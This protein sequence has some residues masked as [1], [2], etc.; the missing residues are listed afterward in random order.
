MIYIVVLVIFFI[1]V[2]IGALYNILVKMTNKVDEVFAT[3]DVYLKKRWDLI[4]SLVEMVKGYMKHE[5]DTLQEIV[6]IR[7][8]TYDSMSS[9]EKIDVNEK[10][11]KLLL[12]VENYPELKASD[13]IFSLMEQLT[14]LEDEIASSRKYYNAIVR[15][16]NN[17]VEIFPNNLVAK[18]LGFKV[19]L[20]FTASDSEKENLKIG[21]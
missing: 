3:M 19:R 4:P 2:Y 21:L 12:L 10:I 9:N 8:K 6:E 1:I 11:N 5:K 18:I 15:L 7:N 17:K 13:N 14:K 16:Y 20:M